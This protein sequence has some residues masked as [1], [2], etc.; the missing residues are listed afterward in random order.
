MSAE[1]A[2]TLNAHFGEKQGL[3]NQHI[4]GGGGYLSRAI[5]GTL[6]SRDA[7][8]ARMDADTNHLIPTHQG[9]F[10]DGPTHTLR[11]S[12]FDASED[13]TGRGT[14]I[15]T[16]PTLTSNGDNDLGYRDERGLVPVSL[17]QDSEFGVEEYDTAGSLRAGRIPAHQMIIEPQAAV[18][19]IP[20]ICIKGASIGRKPEAG[21]QFGEHLNE[22][23][24]T[25]NCVDVHGVMT[26]SLSVRRLTPKECE[27]LQGFP[28]HW[29]DV[30]YRKKPACD[31]P[32]Y[33]ALGNSM[34]VPCMK[35]IGEGI[36]RDRASIPVMEIE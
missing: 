31:G 9:G 16:V 26:P 1:I 35:K 28:D 7:K 25:Q 4:D 21:P 2:P 24:Y 33:K 36:A 10:F 20:A 3:E 32:R 18:G 27:R 12:G 5:A 22:L 29:T 34:A 15:V 13:D 6:C 23:A 19:P 17:F 30:P 8:S 11:A 14:P